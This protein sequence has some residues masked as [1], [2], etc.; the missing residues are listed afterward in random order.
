MLEEATDI[1]AFLM[2][3]SGLA[4]RATVIGY[5]YIQRGGLN[6]KVYAKDLVTDGMF[7]VCRNPLYVGNMLIYSGIFLKHGSPLVMI[8]GIA[9]FAFIYQCIV[10]AE[11]AFLDN[12]FGSGYAAYCRDVPR[13]IPR[14]SK[15]AE[16]TEGMEFNFKRVIAKDYSTASAALFAIIAIEAC[17]FLTTTP[18]PTQYIG[19]PSV[20]VAL[21]ATVGVLAGA[22]SFLKKR[23]VF[24]EG[25]TA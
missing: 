8:V 15:F 2:V 18:D 12:K 9:L 25:K 4:F 20:L 11:E 3:L 22:I 19:Y 23:G 5:A 1:I 16:S 14:F 24:R 13:W 21:M 7:G 6:K 10:Y 17:E